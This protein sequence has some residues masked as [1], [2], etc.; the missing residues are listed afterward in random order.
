MQLT[1]EVFAGSVRADD[2][3]QFAVVDAEAH[4]GQRA[5]ATKAQ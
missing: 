1:I 5:D 3:E 2:R 4:F